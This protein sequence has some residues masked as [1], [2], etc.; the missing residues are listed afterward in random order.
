MSETSLWGGGRITIWLL[1]VN[2]TL[3]RIECEFDSGDDERMSLIA[4]GFRDFGILQI[5]AWKMPEDIPAMAERKG[6]ERIWG[7]VLMGDLSVSK[8]VK[9]VG[10]AKVH[11]KAQLLAPA[12][13]EDEEE[14]E[15]QTLEIV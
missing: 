4:H 2:D 1:N 15:T 10:I 3:C 9:R 5:G 14:W 8:K 12:S 11:P 6:D 7:L 13:F